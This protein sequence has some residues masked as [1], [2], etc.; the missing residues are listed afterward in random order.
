[1]QQLPRTP[2]HMRAPT[3]THPTSATKSCCFSHSPSRA[4]SLPPSSRVANQRRPSRQPSSASTAPVP[5]ASSSTSSA[6]PSVASVKASQRASASSPSTAPSPPS[7]SPPPAGPAPASPPPSGPETFSWAGFGQMSDI[8]QENA[9]LLQKLD[10]KDAQIERLREAL[11]DARLQAQTAAN[12]GSSAE[13]W[14]AVGS[15]HL[16]LPA[17]L[18]SQVRL[19]HL[20]NS[21]CC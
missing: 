4:L 19:L 15:Y 10:L 5:A 3:P 8:Q 18:A 6:R 7:S 13:G 21:G 17:L 2:T 20:H 1:M 12:G 9:A 16:V 11:A 14:S